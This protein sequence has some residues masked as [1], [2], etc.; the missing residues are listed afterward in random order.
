MHRT[1]EAQRHAGTK[2]LIFGISIITP[3]TQQASSQGKEGHPEDKLMALSKTSFN[4]HPKHSI[5]CKSSHT[6]LLQQARQT[7]QPNWDKITL[8]AAVPGVPVQLI[9]GYTDDENTQI[10][11]SYLRSSAS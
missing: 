3:V 9:R 5:R 11:S 8:R 6:R 1:S 10:N 2:D 7:Q 4:I